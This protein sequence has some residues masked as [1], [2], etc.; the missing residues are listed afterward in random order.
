MFNATDTDLFRF[1]D[2]PTKPPYFVF[3][4]RLTANKGVH[5]AIDAAE[6]ANVPLKIA[7][8][9]SGESGGR[10]Y[11]DSQVKPRLNHQ[12]E[13][14]GQVDDATKAEPAR[15]CDRIAV[16]DPMEGT[17]RNCDGGST[18]LRVPSDRLAKWLRARSDTCTVRQDFV[19]NSVEEMVE[20]IRNIEAID[21]A[22]C[23]QD[24]E[25]RFS[26]NA[27]VN[28]YLRVFDHLLNSQ[29]QNAC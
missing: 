9:I 10:A 19:V 5:L 29:P 24:A 3:L 27:L 22:E 16:S 4:G 17:V 28:G 21:R 14:I 13:W 11:F 12:I 26:G 20:A 15:R 8:N 25:Q 7:G 6:K 2:S 18:C 23:R 1:V